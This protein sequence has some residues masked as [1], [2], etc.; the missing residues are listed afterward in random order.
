MQKKSTKNE[1]CVPI[2]KIIVLLRALRQRAFEGSQKKSQYLHSPRQ[3]HRR[4]E[5][6]AAHCVL[7]VVVSSSQCWRPCARHAGILQYAHPRSETHPKQL[8]NPGFKHKPTAEWYKLQTRSSKH[9]CVLLC[10]ADPIRWHI[11]QYTAKRRPVSACLVSV[12]RSERRGSEAYNLE[13]SRPC[14]HTR[15]RSCSPQRLQQEHLPSRAGM[16]P[17]SEWALG[18]F[19][20]TPIELRLLDRGGAGT[21]G[22][23]FDD[24]GEGGTEEDGRSQSGTTAAGRVA[25]SSRRVAYQGECLA[26]LLVVKFDGENGEPFF[27]ITLG[28]TGWNATR[29]RRGSASSPPPL[30]TPSLYSVQAGCCNPALQGGGGYQPAYSLT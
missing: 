27:S 19:R 26:G 5:V 1:K 8:G 28:A 18:E 23:G 14:F 29:L 15:N 25:S 9:R 10:E 13:L 4:K 12:R 24:A 30:P 7:C 21:V 11:A 6:C 16:D 22:K 17:K 2:K 3:G 20:D